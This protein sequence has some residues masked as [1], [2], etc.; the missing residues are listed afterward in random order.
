M[1]K[2]RTQ[3]LIKKAS[4]PEINNALR[5]VATASDRQ[6]TEINSLNS[7]IGKL[8]KLVDSLAKQSGQVK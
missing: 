4:V 6:V 1:A 2:I 8:Q 5:R 7:K 3:A